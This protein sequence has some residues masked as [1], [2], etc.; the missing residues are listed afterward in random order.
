MIVRVLV[1]RGSP[2]ALDHVRQLVVPRESGSMLAALP[3]STARTNL[4]PPRNVLTPIQ[5]IAVRPGEPGVSPDACGTGG[6]AY[7]EADSSPS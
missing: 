1:M 4:S 5:S 3:R 2:V 6:M 7:R